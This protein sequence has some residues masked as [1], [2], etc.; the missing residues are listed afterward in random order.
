MHLQW[1]SPGTCILLFNCDAFAV[2]AQQKLE[3]VQQD[4]E[5]VSL[6]ERHLKETSTLLA[7]ELDKQRS[8][9]STSAS[10][11]V[12]MR[13]QLSA[14]QQALQNKEATL[15]EMRAELQKGSQVLL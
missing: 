3:Q 6:R 1:N 15:A 13:G 2:E 5:E 7:N 14:M 8:N 9:E 12:D 10:E 11:I 4:L